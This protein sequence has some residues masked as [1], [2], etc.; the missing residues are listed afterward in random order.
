MQIVKSEFR[1][2]KQNKVLS[3]KQRKPQQ[4]V[5]KLLPT[6]IAFPTLDGTRYIRFEN[7]IHCSSANNYCKVILKG[8]EEILLSKTLKWVEDRLP[9][10]FFVRVHASHLVN[11]D[12]IS[13]F[14]YDFLLL[15]NN[16]QIPV[17]RSR[18][19]E[20]EIKLNRQCFL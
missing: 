9:S 12:Y 1:L 13:K 5:Y 2:C 14:C 10:E 19:I 3:L 6:K 17:S 15:E 8:G 11:I 16:S 4:I 20:L 18:K 7:I